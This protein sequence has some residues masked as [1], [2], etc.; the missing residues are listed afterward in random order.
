MVRAVLCAASP[1]LVFVFCFSVLGRML[2]QHTPSSLTR[3]A[4][5]LAPSR[6]PVPLPCAISESGAVLGRARAIFLATS[7][8][9]G[10]AAPAESWNPDLNLA[11][12][13]LP[14]PSPVLQIRQLALR[15][16]ER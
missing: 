10:S 8:S 11:F 15:I 13:S 6:F 14:S 1:A 16:M 9:A 5:A 12:A 3:A 4:R 2:R 7:H